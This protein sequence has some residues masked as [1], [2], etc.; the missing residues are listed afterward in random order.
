MVLCGTLLHGKWFHRIT[1]LLAIEYFMIFVLKDGITMQ[2]MAE[3]LKYVL[4]C[5]KARDYETF[6]R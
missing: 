5:W 2:T 3:T 6:Y 4:T 1:P